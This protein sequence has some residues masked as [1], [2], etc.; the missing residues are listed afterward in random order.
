[1][2]R[3]RDPSLGRLSQAEVETLLL[4]LILDELEALILRD[5]GWTRYRSRSGASAADIRRGTAE[6]EW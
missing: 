3:S 6:G 1:M 2:Y 4:K 5:G